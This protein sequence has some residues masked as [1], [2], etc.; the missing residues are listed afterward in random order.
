MFIV[1]ILWS[2]K[3]VMMRLLVCF[4]NMKVLIIIEYYWKI[5]FGLDEEKLIVLLKMIEF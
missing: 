5:V 4:I 1:F 3:V 2:V